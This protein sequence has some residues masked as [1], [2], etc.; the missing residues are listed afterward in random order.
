MTGAARSNP[1]ENQSASSL[2]LLDRI[3]FYVLLIVLCVRPL[4]GETFE[5]LQVSF[6]TALQAGPGATPATTA[7]LDS[8]LLATAGLALTRRGRWRRGR[9]IAVAV[10]LLAAAVALSTSVAGDKRSALLAG[11]NM[12]ITVLAGTALVSLVRTRWMQNLLLAGL[13]ATGATTAVKCISQRWYENPLTQQRW[14]SVYKPELIR[15]GFDPHDPLFINFERRMWAGEAYGFLAHPNVT[16]T[17]LLMWLLMAGGLLATAAA[18]MIRAVRSAAPVRWRPLVLAAAV[19]VLLGI[20]LPQTGSRGAL[21]AA[22]LGVVLL[23]VF[24]W[25]APGVARRARAVLSLLIAG[26]LAVVAA[27]LAYGLK[28]DTL[29]GASLAF[30]WQ[31]WTAAWRVWQEVPL[32]GLGRDNFGPAYLH[33]KRAESPEEVRDPHNLW[34]SLVVELGPLGLV[35]GALLCGA[36]VLA[37]LRSLSGPPGGSGNRVPLSAAQAAPLAV[38]VLIVHALL[39]GTPF[40]EPGVWLVWGQEI[41]LTWILALLLSLPLLNG[42]ESDRLR[43]PWLGAGLCAALCATLVHSLIGFTLLTPAGAGLFALCA[44]GAAM[45]GRVPQDAARGSGPTRAAR[46]VA[47]VALTAVA[48]AFHVVW[49]ARPTV[50]DTRTMWDL[51]VAVRTAPPRGGPEVV[52]ATASEVL[53]ARTVAPPIAR[54]AARALLR[55]SYWPG[56]SAAE[57]LGLLDQAD[58]CAAR[59]CAVDPGDAANY[60]LAATVAGELADTQQAVRRFAEAAQEQRRAAENW[61]RAVERYP[62]SSNHRIAAGTAWLAIWKRSGDGAAARLAYEDFR[63]AL[64]IDDARPAE[65]AVRLRPSERRR[66]VDALAVL[67]PSTTTSSRPRADGS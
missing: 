58:L 31:Y 49:V 6:V 22:G 62:T 8:V 46:A 21:L 26:Y 14:E 65:E 44:V 34:V 59:A 36:C 19:C 66:A 11:S 56:L 33:Y 43:A 3:L 45:L 2:P 13:L 1:A 41:A 51:D 53:R 25:R 55:V 5:Y 67:A 35:G 48:V 29:P 64:R 17:A 18:A 54:A 27:G 63:A 42:L 20:A 23:V 16:A 52:R 39:S 57:R 7:A 12:V 47:A 4:L 40:G 61:Q 60:V 50:A 9:L 15:Q 30:R 28:K 10:V 37:A 32:T 24:G 38:G